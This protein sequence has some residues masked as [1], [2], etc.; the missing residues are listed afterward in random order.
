MDVKMCKQ[1]SSLFFLPSSAVGAASKGWQG[2]FSAI[3]SSG[4]R[5]LSFP[6]SHKWGD[7]AQRIFSLQKAKAFKCDL[8]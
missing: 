4:G 5:F 3:Y 6:I 7:R 1:N 8:F 2:A